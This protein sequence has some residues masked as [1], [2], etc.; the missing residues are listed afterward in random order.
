MKGKNSKAH[1][2]SER[3]GKR[4]GPASSPGPAVGGSPGSVNK[5]V[6]QPWAEL[7]AQAA[8]Q[9]LKVPAQAAKEVLQPLAELLPA[10]AAT[11]L[12]QPGPGAA[13]AELH[14][15]S[16]RRWTGAALAELHNTS[17]RRWTRIRTRIRIQKTSVQP[18]AELQ[19]QW[20]DL[21][22]S[23]ER[24]CAQRHSQLHRQLHRQPR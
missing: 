2:A 3:H 21:V 23:D 16:K 13:L 15:K 24:S 10:Q 1:S 18:L 20:S 5:N 7:P 12:V 14:N 22:P 19:H 9:V 17:K 4:T 8:K 6:F 11:E